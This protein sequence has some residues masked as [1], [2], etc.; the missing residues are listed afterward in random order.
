MANFGIGNIVAEKAAE[1][2]ANELQEWSNSIRQA[3]LAKFQGH[4]N[5][6]NQCYIN[7][8]SSL[9]P[10]STVLDNLKKNDSMKNFLQTYPSGKGGADIAPLEQNY[11]KIRQ[12]TMINQD[13]IKNTQ[14]NIQQTKSA[15]EFKKISLEAMRD[16]Y[17]LKQQ[18][19][20]IVE[21]FAFMYEGVGGAISTVTVPVDSFFKEILNVNNAEL[22]NNMFNLQT[23]SSG[24]SNFSLRFNKSYIFENSIFSQMAFQSNQVQ[25][26][27]I[28]KIYG[29]TA[30]DF[31]NNAKQQAHLDYVK[32]S[33]LTKAEK[34]D[35]Q[36]SGIYRRGASYLVVRKDFETGFLSQS[37]FNS[38]IN[39]KNFQYEKDQVP[40]YMGEDVRKE[41]TNI[42][43]SVKSFLEG[44][45]TLMSMNS[46]DVA[47]SKIIYV[48]AV[49]HD[50]SKIKDTLKSYVFSAAQTMDNAFQTE[51]RSL[52]LVG[53]FI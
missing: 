37:I 13:I 40:W 3:Y 46:L 33:K 41:G 12:Q 1:G 8:N 27:D 14:Q 10:I 4:R 6:L 44:A 9:K 45:P 43:Y 22:M 36:K 15:Y 42:G 19:T 16:V 20:G 39:N 26:F 47:L 30:M 38:Y 24:P 48:L 2:G 31:Y 34:E 5:S 51:L 23:S 28:E 50:A 53:G 29:G 18:V 21:H 17:S 7:F 32:Y 11:N 52:P 25:K 49:Q 35:I